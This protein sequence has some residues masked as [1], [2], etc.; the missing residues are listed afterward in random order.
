MREEVGFFTSWA[1][2][3]K[4]AVQVAVFGINVWICHNLFFAKVP[5]IQAYLY[6]SSSDT[7]IFL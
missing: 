5:I 1:F 7:R 6:L 2:H 3:C 4:N